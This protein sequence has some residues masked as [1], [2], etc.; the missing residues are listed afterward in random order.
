MK[1]NVALEKQMRRQPAPGLVRY[2]SIW[3]T[4]HLAG[5]HYR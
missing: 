5:A 1:R 2:A 4:M 3:Q